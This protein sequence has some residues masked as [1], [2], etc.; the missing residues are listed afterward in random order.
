MQGRRKFIF[1]Y[2]DE[3]MRRLIALA[4]AATT[5]V[6]LALV[7][8]GAAGPGSSLG[9]FFFGPKLVR[10]EVVT[11]E[12][13]TIHD[14]RVDRGKIRGIVRASL[15]LTLLERD[16]TLVTVPVAPTANVTLGGVTVPFNMLRRGFTAT[17][18]RDGSAA[19]SIVQ[20]TRR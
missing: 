6:A 12:A 16:G 19:A 15:T 17:T 11:N 14:Y 18:V 2:E 4:A 10:A 7:Q 5:I 20:A 8:A 9:S 1:R 13:G 3:C